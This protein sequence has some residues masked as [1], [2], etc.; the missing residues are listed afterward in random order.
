MR[1][2][3][4]SFAGIARTEVAVGTVSEASI[5]ATT[6]A[7]T[8]RIGSTRAAPG[9]A[10]CWTGLGTGSAGVGVALTRGC[11]T[12]G[13]GVKFCDSE[14][15]GAAGT[16]VGLLAALWFRVTALGTGGVPGFGAVTLEPLVECVATDGF[17]VL[18]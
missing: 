7:P 1:L 4:K 13:C 8:P 17:E 3:I 9:V 14:E 10:T 18:A 5:L 12:V 15:V 6:R 16:E 11:E 2:S